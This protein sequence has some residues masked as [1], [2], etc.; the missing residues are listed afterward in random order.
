[1]ETVLSG[2]A[3]DKC[4]VYLDDIPVVRKSFEE[5][6]WNLWEALGRLRKAGLQLKLGKCHQAK[7]EVAYLGYKVSNQGITTDPSK[8]NAVKE[9]PTP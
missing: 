2:L 6:L 4:V 3:Q 1:M 7:W 5:R 9:F 8:V